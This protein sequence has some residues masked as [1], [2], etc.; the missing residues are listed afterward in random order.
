MLETALDAEA[1]AWEASCTSRPYQPR[2]ARRDPQALPCQQ[3]ASRIVLVLLVSFSILGLS[4][5]ACGT[6]AGPRATSVNA[7]RPITRRGGLPSGVVA[8]VG[9]QAITQRAV[10]HWMSVLVITDGHA[11]PKTPDPKLLAPRPP[12]YA[13]C[14]ADAKG[15]LAEKGTRLTSASIKQKCASL[16]RALREQAVEVLIS[17]AQLVDEGAERGIVL[18]DKQVRRLLA[19]LVRA[20][21]PSEAAYRRY[22]HITKQ[23]LRDQ[24][25]HVRPMFLAAKVLKAVAGGPDRTPTPAQLRGLANATK[26]WIAATTCRAGYVV[27]RCREYKASTEQ[28]P[29]V[30]VLIAELA[31]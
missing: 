9:P 3:M 15:G 21:F 14:I 1:P 10:E 20:E 18:N 13:T 6:S 5:E 12:S 16:R 8:K 4:L 31:L 27:P 22:L 2:S 24:I 30:N 11:I 17:T 28:P 23:S 29:A 25:Y 7:S 19:G 26:K